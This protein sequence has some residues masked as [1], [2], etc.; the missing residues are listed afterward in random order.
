M[1]NFKDFII[2]EDVLERYY[3]TEKEVAIPQGVSLINWH[4]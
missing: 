4:G 1:N 3:G 2:K